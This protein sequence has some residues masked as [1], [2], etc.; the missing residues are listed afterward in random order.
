MPDSRHMRDAG[1]REASVWLVNL[2]WRDVSIGHGRHRDQLVDHRRAH[3]RACACMYGSAVNSVPH[4]ERSVGLCRPFE[5]AQVAWCGW[6]G[7][8]SEHGVW[9]ASVR[10]LINETDGGHV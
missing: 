8:T 9:E 3:V 2:G 4:Q 6:H 7:T 10:L 1:E 5:C